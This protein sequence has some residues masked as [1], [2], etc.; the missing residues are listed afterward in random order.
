MSAVFKRYELELSK[1]KNVSSSRLEEILG[2]YNKTYKNLNYLKSRLTALR[3]VVKKNNHISIKS[4]NDA[5][6]ILKLTNE[7]EE[8][9]EKK[10]QTQLEAMN[11][12]VIIV[13]KSELEKILKIE[14]PTLLD[15]I[16]ISQFSTGR[17]LIEILTAK[18]SVRGEASVKEGD[19]FID[20]IAKRHT[21]KR[22]LFKIKS[23]LPVN[24]V[25]EMIDSLQSEIKNNIKGKTNSQITALFLNRITRRIGR[26]LHPVI[27]KSGQKVKP[28][29][30]FLRKI[31]CNYLYEASD[32]NETYDSFIQNVLNHDSLGCSL[33]YSNIVIEERDIK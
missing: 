23:I 24:K 29:S 1:V 21:T 2:E 11:K 3:K 31:Y 9:V 25:L 27:K 7:Q 33:N 19:L 20:G 28:T 4:H 13:Q 17:R 30:H 26:Y 8:Q 32:K 18:F 6:R 22:K 14:K 15:K 12:H 10:S 16:I 5:L